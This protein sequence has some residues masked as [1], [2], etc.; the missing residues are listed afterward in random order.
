LNLPNR[1]T[2]GR[3]LLAAVLFVLLSTWCRHHEDGGWPWYVVFAIYLVTVLSDG[4]DGYL[5][6]ARNQITAFG[7]IT[8]PFADKVVICGVLVLCLDLTPTAPLVPA[9]IV[10]VVLAREFLVSGLRGFL[11]GQGRS[12]G[13]STA[14]KVKMIV[15]A[16]YCGALLFYPGHFMGWVWAV[17]VAALWAT[18]VISVYSAFLYV[19]AARA[20]LDGGDGR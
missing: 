17:A 5:A 8:D 11:E 6:R 14:G 13:S 3:L 2:L 1:I 9:W 7:R 4:L 18:L 10:I 20:A 15:Q 12:F 19:R 16:V